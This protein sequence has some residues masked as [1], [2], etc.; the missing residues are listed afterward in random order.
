MNLQFNILI[1]GNISSGKSTLV[2]GILHNNLN[3]MSK[4]QS[5]LVPIKYISNNKHIIHTIDFIQK[6]N[7]THAVARPGGLHGGTHIPHGEYSRHREV[8]KRKKNKN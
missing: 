1:C 4:I 5:T 2:N 3:K 7:E 8:L 6:Q